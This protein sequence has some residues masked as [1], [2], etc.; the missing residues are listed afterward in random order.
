MQKTVVLVGLGYQS[1][2]VHLPAIL[3]SKQLRLIGVVEIDIDRA[4]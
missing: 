3:N 1:I 2:K 4:I